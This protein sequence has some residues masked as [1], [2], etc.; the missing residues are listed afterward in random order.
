MLRSIRL[1]GRLQS[2]RVQGVTMKVDDPRT[3]RERIRRLAA[4][5]FPDFSVVF[6][7]SQPFT[8][9]RFRFDQPTLHQII[10]TPSG[11]F[12]VSE[13]AEWPDD[14]VRNYMR[15]LAPSFVR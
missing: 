14:K 5:V 11:H 2:D 7:E 4:E 1:V 15:A 3:Q 13:I 6:D 10:G 8:W 12:H 9:I